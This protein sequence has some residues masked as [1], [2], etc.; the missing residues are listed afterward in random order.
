MHLT[1]CNL[2]P[3]DP[4]QLLCELQGFTAQSVSG[5]VL[6]AGAINAHNTFA[7][8]EAVKPAPFSGASVTPTGLTVT[9]PPKSVV[10]LAVRP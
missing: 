8:P 10:A 5:Q 4:A 1:L 2:N 6:T 9:L 3:N 7:Q